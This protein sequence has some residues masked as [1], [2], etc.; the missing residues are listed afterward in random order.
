MSRLDAVHARL[1]AAGPAEELVV[2]EDDV[3]ALLGV[4]E[5][6]VAFNEWGGADEGERFDALMDALDALT[7]EREGVAA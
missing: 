6:A 5:A 2:T 4:A 3:A 1:Q 7:E